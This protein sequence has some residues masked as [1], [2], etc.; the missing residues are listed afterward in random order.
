MDDIATDS[1]AHVDGGWSAGLGSR[2]P[3]G[4]VSSGGAPA[5]SG[6]EPA[7]RDEKS[8][9]KSIDSKILPAMPVPDTSK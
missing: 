1:V 9:F 8:L 3:L 2:A 7:G 4:P 5:G 6:S